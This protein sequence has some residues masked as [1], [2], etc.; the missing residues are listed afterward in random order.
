M[1]GASPNV[2]EP[3]ESSNQEKQQ[4]KPQEHQHQSDTKSSSNQNSDDSVCEPKNIIKGRTS[5]CF[6]NLISY[7]PVKFVRAW[8]KL[9]LS[10][11]D[12]LDDISYYLQLYTPVGL[13]D[14]MIS[15]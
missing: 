15:K 9:D 3:V 7:V 2:V 6:H 5:F 12:L 11:E 1:T 14:T 4:L 10:A 13:I 8:K